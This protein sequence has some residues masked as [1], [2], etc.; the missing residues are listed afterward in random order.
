MLYADK[1]FRKKM[2]MHLSRTI[3]FAECIQH[4]S[5]CDLYR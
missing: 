1:I 3:L 4:I 2:A 5:T